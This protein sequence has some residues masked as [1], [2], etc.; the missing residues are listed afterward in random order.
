[1]A[2]ASPL[3]AAPAKDKVDSP[4]VPLPFGSLELDGVL[5]ER[6][7]INREKRLSH[8]DQE[9]LL[10]GFQ[11]RPGKHPWIGEHIGKYLH[12]AANAWQYSKDPEL[13]QHMD[14]MAAQ[15][16]ATQDSDGY[17]GTYTRAERWTSW[18]VWVHK[19]DLIGLLSYNA[20]T[21]SAPALAAARK[22]GDLLIRTFGN[23]PGQIQIWKTGDH[24]G[25]ASTSVLEPMCQLYRATG[26]SRYLDFAHYIVA[27]WD[28]PGGP[29]IAKSL[30]ATH[31]VRRTA[32]AKGYEMLSNLVGLVELYRI[33][34]NRDLLAPVEIAW[35]DIVKNR[36]YITGTTTSKEY[37]RDDLRLPA[38]QRAEVGEGC[39]TV[40]WLQLNLH[41][42]RLTG[43]CQYADELEKTVFNH[44]LAAQDKASGNI[45]YFTP[46]VGIKEPGPGISCCV[47]SV[48]RG[49]S[50][51]PQLAG[52]ELHDGVVILLYSPGRLRA[53]GFALK[54]DTAFPAEGNVQISI[55]SAPSTQAPIFLRVPP[56][57]HTFTAKSGGRKY[58]GVPGT[59]IK[60]ERSWKA[61]DKIEIAM[62]M[63]VTQI[64]GAPEY[65][66]YVALRRGPQVMSLEASHNPKVPYLFRAAPVSTTLTRAADGAYTVKGAFVD[67]NRQKQNTT[68]TLVPYMDSTAPFVW[69]KSAAN[70]STAP[71]AVT[72]YGKERWSRNGQ[73][74][75]SICDERTD[76]YG[77][78]DKRATP[79]LDYFQVQLKM[80]AAVQRLVFAHG[81]STPEGGW[82][83][84]APVFEAQRVAGGPWERL[85][86][87]P[88]YRD[89]ANLAAGQSFELK[90]PAPV[91]IAAL[92]VSGP[93]KG[94]ASCA[95]LA[96]YRD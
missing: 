49:I 60:L 74:G 55:E 69:L 7:K 24:L 88:G 63:A 54:M 87:V 42:L 52:G 30:Q 92:R 38:S 81:K 11:H 46:L 95:E 33:T 3:A 61:G 20:A 47:S 2:L 35:A 76:T 59:I 9:G 29:A 90:L 96:A 14:S 78:T 67:A 83:A 72:A 34:G 4:F 62:D 43:D 36:L 71:V 51:L 84:Q 77:T 85:G 6:M 45:C 17:L 25:M 58:N 94:Y 21:G 70:L 26:D 28:Q 39:V 18:D 57:A 23:A 8:V 50:M 16:I 12:A 44:L 68:L 79:A 75:G 13:K 19:Y 27:S 86:A 93:A 66:G 65:P 32:N 53:K 56:W 31:S 22:I 15:W 37:F 73:E 89:G 5:G 40:T 91:E 41:L 48:P 82:F 64:D 10:E 1:M 80:P